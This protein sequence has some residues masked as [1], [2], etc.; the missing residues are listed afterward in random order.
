MKDN[1]KFRSLTVFYGPFP[2]SR[3]T[4]GV[5]FCS[6]ECPVTGVRDRV[7]YLKTRG[8]ST[9]ARACSDQR[10]LRPRPPKRRQHYRNMDTVEEG[11]SLR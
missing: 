8:T 6:P 1:R 9:R 11:G 10:Q 7:R 3:V 5:R 2:C 4:S